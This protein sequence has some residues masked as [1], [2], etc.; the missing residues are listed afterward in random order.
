[1]QHNYKVLIPVA[2]IVCNKKYNSLLNIDVFNKT[3]NQNNYINLMMDL[4][5]DLKKALCGGIKTNITDTLLSKIV[6]VT[7]GCVV[8]YDKNVNN[9]LRKLKYKASYTKQ[10]LND[11]VNFANANKNDILTLQK[12]Y[13]KY[14]YSIM[15]ICDCALY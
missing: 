10:G 11:L 8:C 4:K 15:K 12:T 5:T 6:H 1:M 2:K 7:L 14:N 9:N 3:F 13:A